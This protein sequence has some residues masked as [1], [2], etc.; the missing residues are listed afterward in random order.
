MAKVSLFVLF[1]IIILSA[2]NSSPI[3]KANA[4]IKEDLPKSL[5]S[6]TNCVG[7]NH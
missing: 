6:V 5:G 1:V 3:D 2:C 4:L 7:K